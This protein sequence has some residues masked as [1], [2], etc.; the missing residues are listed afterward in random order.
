MPE[1]G[2]VRTYRKRLIAN[3]ECVADPVLTL[4]N[5]AA[6]KPCFD[7]IWLEIAGASKTVQCGNVLPLAGKALAEVQPGLGDVGILRYGQTGESFG[8]GD[9][10]QLQEDHRKVG[11]DGRTFWSM[12]VC[13]AQ[14]VC[15]RGEIF[16]LQRLH[17]R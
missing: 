13:D 4:Q 5:G 17:C 7:Q 9:L 15:G 10:A 1:A 12:A 11:Q 3:E 8:L 6:G 14:A 16:A 2:A